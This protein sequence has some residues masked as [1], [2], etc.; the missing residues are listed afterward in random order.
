MTNTTSVNTKEQRTNL[1]P[2]LLILL[3]L[4]LIGNAYLIYSNQKFETATTATIDNLEVEKADL[5]ADFD[6]MVSELD[7]Y[8]GENMELDASL[9][10][11]ETEI[12]S[13]KQEIKKLLGKGNASREE[14]VQAKNLIE[15]LRTISKDYKVRIDRLIAE[16]DVLTEENVGLKDEVGKKTDTIAQL[17]GEK[18]SLANKTTILAE[19]KDLL[20]KVVKRGSVMMVNDLSAGGIKV[21]NSGKEVETKNDKQTDK[22]RICFDVMPNPIADQGSKNIL[23]RIVSP[24]GTTL[25]IQSFGSGIF[26]NTESGQES[27]YTTKTTIA[28]NGDREKHCMYWEQNTP[29]SAGLYTSELYHDGYWIGQTTFELK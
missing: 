10:Q 24:E 26:K 6:E 19:Q 20:Q 15:S 7:D 29:F 28:F 4:S 12:E 27:K 9:V 13:Q 21:R 23:A 22:I 1:Q 18:Q 25:F 17:E 3:L 11:L 5:Q 14:L 8:K 16:N 2:I